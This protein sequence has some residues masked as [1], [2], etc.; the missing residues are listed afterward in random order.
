MEWLWWACGV[1]PGSTPDFISEVLKKP[2]TNVDLKIF[3]NKLNSIFV[4]N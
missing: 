3:L 1:Q 2:L 4:Y